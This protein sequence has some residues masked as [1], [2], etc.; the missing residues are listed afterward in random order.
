MHTYIYTYTHTQFTDPLSTL[1][2]AECAIPQW[3][4]PVQ[5]HISYTNTT[6]YVSSNQTYFE[7]HTIH[8][9]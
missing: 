2:A 8:D 1:T 7:S 9:S 4:K 6:Y 3:Y 5:T